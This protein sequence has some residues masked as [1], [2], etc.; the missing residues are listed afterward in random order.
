[1]IFYYGQRNTEKVDA[2]LKQLEQG[3]GA[4]RTS[5]YTQISNLS[6]LCRYFL[7]P[8]IRGSYWKRETVF[9]SPGRKSVKEP[10][11]TQNFDF[12]Y[13]F[14][15]IFDQFQPD[16][17]WCDQLNTNR[18]LGSRNWDRNQD[19][20]HPIRHWVSFERDACQIPIQITFLETTNFFEFFVVTSIIPN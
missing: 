15:A 14:E 7:V 11:H 16:R 9:W 10:N 4:P 6:T 17:W 3:Y 5:D 20:I 19:L 13:N 12:G 18:L 2:K 1:M 8:K